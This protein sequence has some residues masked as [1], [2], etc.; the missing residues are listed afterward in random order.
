MS[1][2]TKT[3][4]QLAV[5]LYHGKWGKV[6]PVLKGET[7]AVIRSGKDRIEFIHGKKGN[8]LYIAFQG[9]NGIIDF[10]RDIQML[11]K[12]AIDTSGSRIHHGFWTQYLKS[13]QTILD[14][15]EREQPSKVIFTG[16]SLGAAL[17]TIH[18]YMIPYEIA[19]HGIFIGSPRVGNKNFCCDFARKNLPCE[20]YT[21]G[22]DMVTDLPCVEM[23]Y[24]HVTKPIWI[25]GGNC[26]F[27]PILDHSPKYY[28]IGYDNFLKLKEKL[29]ASLLG[30]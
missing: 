16:H 19:T 12:D 28:Q 26:F 10:Y 6:V 3:C 27:R 18:Q 2:Y 9:T 4:F 13:Q 8:T 15:I 7:F 21:N 25:N 23:G 5:N 11:K 17:A 1:A 24:A 14:L 30:D 22:R 29:N 20:L